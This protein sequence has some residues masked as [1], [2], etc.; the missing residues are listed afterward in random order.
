MLR[1]IFAQEAGEA[2]RRRENASYTLVDN[3]ERKL[4]TQSWESPTQSSNFDA[5][6]ADLERQLQD[7]Q[8]KCQN[9]VKR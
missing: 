5:I 9:Y 7:A 6:K 1:N 4:Y 2:L 8:M 3:L